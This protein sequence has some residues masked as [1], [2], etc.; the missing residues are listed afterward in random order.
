MDDQAFVSNTKYFK[1]PENSLPEG[2]YVVRLRI[3]DLQA[4][5][6]SAKQFQIIGPP[7]SGTITV[8]PNQGVVLDEEFEITAVD[9]QDV[10]E[11]LPLRYDFLQDGKILVGDSFSNVLRTKLNGAGLSTLSVIVKNNKDAASDAAGA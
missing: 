2:I 6:E 4:S 10:D 8:T 9:W 7:H 3:E 11:N 5:N 1:I